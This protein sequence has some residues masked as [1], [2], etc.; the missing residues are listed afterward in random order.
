MSR[1]CPLP[2]HGHSTLMSKQPYVT[3]CAVRDV[4]LH[5]PHDT[6]ALPL[7]KEHTGME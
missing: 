1:R 6:Y 4:T 3:L 5:F 7:Y 2:D